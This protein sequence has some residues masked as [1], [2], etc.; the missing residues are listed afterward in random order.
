MRE[1]SQRF[2]DAMIIKSWQNFDSCQ[3]LSIWALDEFGEFP[4]KLGLKRASNCF[5]NSQG[6]R[7]WVAS[8]MPQLSDKLFS[9]PKGKHIELLDW[10]EKSKIDSLTK[11]GSKTTKYY[12]EA[13]ESFRSSDKKATQATWS[14]N[15]EKNLNNSNQWSVVK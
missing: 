13:R 11:R 5:G 15:L 12:N 9:L 8:Y 10:L 6:V 4:S 3:K 2:W 14:Y 7:V 1:I